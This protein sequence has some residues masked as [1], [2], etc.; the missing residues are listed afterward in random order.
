MKN[1]AQIVPV[2]GKS[3]LNDRFYC[4]GFQNRMKVE[5]CINS[6][7]DANAL[8]RKE[9]P[10]FNCQQGLQVRLDFANS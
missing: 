3:A 10:C 1:T 4:R 9:V 2:C 7:V 8:Q 6:Y 5:S